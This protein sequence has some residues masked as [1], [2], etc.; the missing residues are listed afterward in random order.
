MGRYTA[1]QRIPIIVRGQGCY[2]WDDLG[3]RYLDGLSALC[4]V[5][6]GHGRSELAS[7]AFDQANELGFFPN[8]GYAHPGA[9]RLAHRLASLAPGPLNR[10]FFTSGGSEAVES[11]WKLTRSYHRLRGEPTRTKIIAREAAYHGTSLGALSATGIPSLRAE[12][13]PLVPGAC[14]VPNTRTHDRPAAA[15]ASWAADA[16]ER[17][18]LA[19]DPESIGAIILEP[20]QSGGGCLTPPDGYFRRIRAICDKY[21]IV[22]IADE[23]TTAWGRLGYSFGCDRYDFQPDMIITAKGLTS[24]YAP[25]GAVIISDQISEL[26]MKGTTRFSHGFTFGGHPVS[27]AVALAN[28]DI[29]EREDLYGQ[30]RSKEADFR[31]V[32]HALREL[33][34]VGDVRGAGYFHAVELVREGGSPE[35]ISAASH[36]P[37]RRDA[38]ALALQ[39][40]GLLCRV[41][42]ERRPIIQ[43]A[44]PLIA[45]TEQF[46]E[47]G[48]ILYESLTTVDIGTEGP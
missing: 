13:E 21:G 42:G 17:R 31:Q 24:G 5:N 30:V 45:G 43:L 1:S 38:L 32:L 11:A 25:L 28:L 23:V 3:T 4:C 34:V 40:R 39:R 27:C 7:A 36:L 14:H 19:E 2:V 35:R 46:R 9:V 10:V 6:V 18:I 44:P 15:P 33:P 22:L 8:W 48:Q 20:V 37:S 47:M 26:F 16:I 41:T 29:L 12:F